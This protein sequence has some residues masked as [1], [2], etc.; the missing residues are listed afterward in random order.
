MTMPRVSTIGRRAF[1]AFGFAL[2]GA[3]MLIWAA[4]VVMAQDSEELKQ[5][6]LTEKHIAGFI[7]AQK[8]MAPLSSKLLEGGEKPDDALL[9]ELETIAKKNGFS[10]FM[11]MEIVGANIAI[12]LDGLDPKT[13]EYTDP[14][15]KMKLEMEN[16]RQDTALSEKD[17]ELVIEDLKQE[18]AAAKPLQFK[19]NIDLVKKFQGE[20]E[21]LTVG[22]TGESAPPP[23]DVPAQPS[24]N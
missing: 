19:D 11:D 13:G 18:I 1:A 24:Q 20:L 2:L 22:D 8:D 21:K 15:E 12:V 7:A 23:A 14:I 9:A 10:S 4:P 17:R 16:I 5:M 6:Q 3:V